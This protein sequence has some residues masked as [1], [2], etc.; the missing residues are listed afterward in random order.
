MAG[1]E[2]PID[3]TIEIVTPE[4]IAF[5][6]RLAG[7]FRRLPA[8]LIDLLFRVALWMILAIICSIFEFTFSADG[9]FMGLVLIALF[10]M[11][12]LYGGVLETLWNGQTVGKLL[13]RIRVISA[14]GQP[15]SP[16]QAMLR[17]FLRFADM[18]PMI[19]L[20]ALTSEPNPAAIP[21]FGFGLIVPLLNARFQRLGDIVCGTMVV[22]EEKRDLFEAPKFQD[23]RIAQ[24][25]AE[26]PPS[27]VVSRTLAKALATYV[28]RRALFS[29][30]RRREIAEHL[31]K[32]LLE[33]FG[34][35]ADTSYDL[36][37]C[38]LY[39]RTFLSVD[40]DYEVMPRAY[41]SDVNQG[42]PFAV[43]K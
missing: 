30:A 27:F 1:P 18:M 4:N 41:S 40:E 22:V 34:M 42:N 36:L 24:L 7:P 5:E 17:N 10:L 16:L 14:D 39:H 32:P 19:P 12:W 29:S 20:G 25:A 31:A 28:D 15:I 23:P 37:L 11:E 33:K 8:F 43:S 26:L 3:T 13:M 2:K 9:T 6:Y 35:P 21:T 38:S